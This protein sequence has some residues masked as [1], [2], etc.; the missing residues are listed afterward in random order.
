MQL[1]ESDRSPVGPDH[2]GSRGLPAKVGVYVCHCGLNIASKVDV[3][4]VV[5]FAALQPGVSVARD[6]KF[7]C[8]DPGQEL[9][10]Q[11]IRDGLVNRVVVASC[12]PLM[13]EATFRRA[14]AAGGLSPFY[15]QM[16]N[17]REDVAWVTT[18]GD[19]A[20]EKAKT[21][22]AAAVRRVRDHEPLER[23]ESPVHPEVLVVG[24]GIAGIH[25]ALT[26]AEA[27]KHVYLVEREATIGGHMARFDKTFPTLDCSACILTPKMSSV[28][29][30]PNI[31]LWTYSDVESV[32][33]FSGDFKVRVRRRPRYVN[34]DLCTGCLSCIDACIYK[35]P[36]TD[37]PWNE[38][39]SKRRPIYMAFPQATPSVVVVDPESCV[40]FKTH[41]C[42]RP[43]VAACERMAM[44]F[45]Q[46]PRIEEIRVGAIILA[47]GFRTFDPHRAPVY[48]Y[49]RFPGVY[50]SMEVERLLN[51]SGPTGGELVMRDGGRPRRVAIVHCVGSRD[52]NTNAYCSRVCCMYSLK[53][54]HL[55]RE[56]SGADVTEFYIDMRTP[57]KGYE[58]FYDRVQKEGT[59]FV[60]G[61]VADVTEEDGSLVVHAE[62]T[63]LGRVRHVP[64][65]MVVL[66]VGME[67]QED[68]EE[69]RRCF[70]IG[71]GG[72]GFFTERHPKLAPVS[73]FTD[74]IFLAGACQGPK[75]IPDTVAQAGAAAAEVLAM[76]D[77][78]YVE[79][80]PAT[81]FVEAT[82]CSGCRTCI[83]MCPFGAISFDPANNVATVNEVLCKGCGTCVAACPSGA[84]QQHL[85]TDRQI[86]DELEGVLS[87]V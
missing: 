51:A 49:G 44:D 39:L 80:E 82:A 16:A 58:E 35:R 63:L 78:G 6:Y 2:N 86:F 4:Q 40:D 79:V 25:A 19:A 37:D 14:T 70:N 81:A 68:A 38:G 36:R 54:A 1:P 57:G 87:A 7:M 62:D 83:G 43:C 23:R 20:T 42:P 21:L 26:M 5:A 85:F 27:G 55:V 65:D 74:G 66:A 64:V 59:Q 17:I 24:G 73:T 29:A 48:G 41:K 72:E 18:D 50:T 32:A 71:C 75:D 9:I 3:S 67:P 61:R 76:V 10:Q 15:F 31:T 47:T 34:E 60:R 12:S 56:R 45:D 8:A 69:V 84:V 77:R 28:R 22:V 53:L 46:K 30:H 11:D 33:G 13:H 52:A